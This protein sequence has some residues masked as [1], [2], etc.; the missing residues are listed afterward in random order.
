MKFHVVTAM[1]ACKGVLRRDMQSTPLLEADAIMYDS[2]LPKE[3]F[4]GGQALKREAFTA[5]FDSLVTRGVVLEC[6]NTA[7]IMCLEIDDWVGFGILYLSGR[8]P[9]IEQKYCM[10]YQSR[11]KTDKWCLPLPPLEI[12]PRPLF[13]YTMYKTG[14]P[15]GQEWFAKAEELVKKANALGAAV[16]NIIG[17]PKESDDGGTT[18]QE[19]G[20]SSPYLPREGS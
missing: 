10:N 8:L 20:S 4:S 12:M 5:T 16:M 2:V 1:H 7:A 13:Y 15:E 6:C 18:T 3:E 11:M 9:P 19:S 14:G 17:L